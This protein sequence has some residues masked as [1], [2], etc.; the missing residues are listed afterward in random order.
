MLVENVKNKTTATFLAKEGIE[1][2][3]NIRNLNYER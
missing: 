2:I 3:Y 1:I